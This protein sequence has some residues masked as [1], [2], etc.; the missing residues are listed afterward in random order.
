MYP[1][2]HQE[3]EALGYK[4]M[5]MIGSDNNKLLAALEAVPRRKSNSL[6]TQSL[7]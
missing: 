4:E 1:T 3:H 7:D 2:N 5:Q 6:S